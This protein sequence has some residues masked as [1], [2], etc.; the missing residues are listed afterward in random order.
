MHKMFNKR[1]LH[2][3]KQ[4]TTCKQEWEKACI[5]CGLLPQKL[6]TPI[7]TRFASTINKFEET[8]EFKQPIITC[9]KRQKTTALQ[10]K[11][12]KAQMWVVAKVL[13][14]ALNHVVTTCV[15][16]QSHGHW[17][18]LNVSTIAIT[19]TV[20]FQFQMAKMFQVLDGIK[21]IN[22][23]DSKLFLFQKKCEKK[24]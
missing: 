12:V 23:F 7:K 5:E 4:S 18:L 13:T 11:V 1:L 22:P 3:Q 20:N 6:K 14:Y 17:F 19:L 15:M 24:L 10:H 16:N 9:Y 21:V 2:K 8:L